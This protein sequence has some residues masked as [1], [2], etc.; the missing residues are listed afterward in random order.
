VEER[1]RSHSDRS[2]RKPAIVDYDQPSW[3]LRLYQPF[4]PVLSLMT[5]SEYP[6][7]SVDT[8]SLF[9]FG[10]DGPGLHFMW[11]GFYFEAS[12]VTDDMLQVSD[13]CLQ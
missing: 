7:S 11:S 4:C 12:V 9:D 1:W 3:L 2:A 5:T 8:F 10:R 13:T 6:M